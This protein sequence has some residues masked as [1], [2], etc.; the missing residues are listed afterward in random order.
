MQKILNKVIWITGA[1]SGIGEAC[2]YLFAEKGARLILTATKVDKLKNVKSKCIELGGNCEI[3][4]YDL[5]DIQGI[6]KLVENALAVY[7]RVDI[8]Y[9]NA[10]ISQ[11]ATAGETLF[12]VD[13]KIM[14]VNFFAPVKITKLL[15][16]K[17]IEQGGATIAVTTSISGRFGFPLRSAYCS[18]K[19]ALYGFFETLQAE[20]YEQNIRIVFVCPG[21]VQTNVSLSALD[22]NGN[23]HSQIDAGQ[24]GGVTADK[25][26]K[27]IVKA[28]IKQKPEVLVGRKELLMLYIKRFLPGLSR[29]LVRKIKP[30]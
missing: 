24:A 23:T 22:K 5:A 1:S 21:R 6:D 2:A 19:H 9:N 28:I 12:K 20:Y 17:M 14:N 26:A 8:L 27:K 30:M 16:P 25:A 29:K 18:S 13:Q 15:L 3:L 4:P 11:R 10:G 7:G